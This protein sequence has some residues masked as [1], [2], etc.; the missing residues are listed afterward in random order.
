MTDTICAL[1]IAAMVAFFAMGGAL[2]SPHSND[3]PVYDG[4]GWGVG[5]GPRF[6]DCQ[7]VRSFSMTSLGRVPAVSSL[8]RRS[9][10]LPHGRY[11]STK[12]LPPALPRGFGKR[13]SMA[14]S[15]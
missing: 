14:L 7:S 4:R 1:L 5:F 9:Q 12:L 6:S 8:W 11:H 13:M 2:V 3:L 10:Q 15:V